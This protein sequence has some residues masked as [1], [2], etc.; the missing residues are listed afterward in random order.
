ML[1]GE[2][3]ALFETLSGKYIDLSKI[4]AVDK[5]SGVTVQGCGYPYGFKVHFTQRNDSAVLFY[6]V[7]D[8][9]HN[10]KEV[11]EWHN[12]IITKWKEFKGE[13]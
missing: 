4:V 3:N 8:M 11:H 2:M 10:K 6:T 5:P 9:D 7:F 1:L 13:S 12:E